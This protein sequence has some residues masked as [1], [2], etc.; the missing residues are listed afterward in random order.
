MI[1]YSIQ[2]PLSPHW[3]MKLWKRWLLSQPHIGRRQGKALLLAAA[4][5]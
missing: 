1:E 4:V 5:P 2:T 3:P